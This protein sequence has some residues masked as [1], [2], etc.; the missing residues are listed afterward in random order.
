MSLS[1]GVLRAPGGG[2]GG[3]GIFR[4]E[5][6]RDSKV[7]A[8]LEGTRQADGSVVVEATVVG[9]GRSAKEAAVTRPFPFAHAEAARRFADETL[10]ALEYLGCEIVS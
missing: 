9:V 7:V 2:A 3:G 10:Q 6:R 5:A 4:H 1:P 8:V